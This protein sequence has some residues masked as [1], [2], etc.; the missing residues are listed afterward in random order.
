MNI[1]TDVK[2]NGTSTP[3][4]IPEKGFYVDLNYMY[5]DADGYNTVT[6]GPFPEDRKDLLVEFLN[7]LEG[8]LAEYPHGKGGFDG[9]ENVPNY[10]KF[11]ETE[12]GYETEDEADA[13]QEIEQLG[14]LQEIEYAPNGYGSVASFE[15]Y[16][17]YYHDGTSLTK[18]DVTVV[19]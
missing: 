6:A 11:F 16:T 10:S 19:Y 8:M 13:A 14:L 3:T 15:G 7:V 2:L 4:E 1:V 12:D 5:G 18:H 17:C 9:Y